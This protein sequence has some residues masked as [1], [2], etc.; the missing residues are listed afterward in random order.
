MDP[1]AEKYFNISPY[2]Y[3]ANNPVNAI[4]PTGE[5]IIFIIRGE[6]R[7]QD[8][9]FT[10]RKGNFYHADGKRYNSGKEGV[11]KTMYNVLTAYRQIEK[12]DDKT[13][14]SQLSTLEK[15][16]KKHYVEE[17]A[18]SAVGVYDPDHAFVSETK[19]AIKN[20]ESMGMDI[21]I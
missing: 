16:E 20:A 21:L 7:K 4:D 15:S 18:R 12:G 19:E 8:Q 10:Y 9:S 3:V 5:E 6:T 1:K 13:L 2:A 14:K 11:S 17:G